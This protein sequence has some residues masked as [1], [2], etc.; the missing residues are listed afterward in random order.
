MTA[1]NRHGTEFEA[2]IYRDMPA[3]ATGKFAVLHVLDIP[4]RATR[5]KDPVTGQPLRRAVAKGPGDIWGWLVV[6]GRTIIAELKSTESAKLRLPIIKPK[7][8][9]SG[10]QFHQLR[11]MAACATCGGIARLVWR[12]GNEIGVVG[13]D[14]L[15]PV[16]NKYRASMGGG[17]MPQG[18][19]SILWG[20]FEKVEEKLVGGKMIWDWLG[21]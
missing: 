6:G 9:A 2:S 13:G 16:Y 3:Y 10:L 21:V 20:A 1:A 18:V 11:A 15:I 17:R 14:V 8:K 12:N 5:Y 4:T 7:S 19:A